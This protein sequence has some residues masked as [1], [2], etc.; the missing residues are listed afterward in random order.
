MYYIGID[1]S[2][3]STGFVCLDASCNIVNKAIIK[4]TDFDDEVDRLS[5][6]IEKINDLL[7][8]YNVD[9]CIIALEGLS[10]HSDFFGTRSICQ[11]SGLHYLVRHD[12]LYKKK[13]KYYVVPPGA[14]KLFVTGRGRASK[15]TMALNV[16]KKW[17]EEFDN[18][19]LVDAYGLARYAQK[20]YVNSIE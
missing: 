8:I 9:E 18:D 17:G 3:T 11:L 13:Y 15:I 7:S 2:L 10:Y 19:D 5:K 4:V 16:L 1:L 6:I 20:K 12:I 14:L